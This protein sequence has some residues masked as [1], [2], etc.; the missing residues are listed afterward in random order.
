MRV[1][2]RRRR[3]VVKRER[4]SAYN[5]VIFHYSTY[6]TESRHPVALAKL[7]CLA[8]PLSLSK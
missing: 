2:E 8:H 1:E 4:V 5:V 6:R 7:Q 3:R